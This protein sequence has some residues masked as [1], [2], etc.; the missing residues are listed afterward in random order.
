M[1]SYRIPEPNRS[2]LA[3]K[4]RLLR[5]SLI[6]GLIVLAVVAISISSAYAAKARPASAADHDLSGNNPQVQGPGNSVEATFWNLPVSIQLDILLTY[7]LV[8][9]GL[10]LGFLGM[11]KL[12]NL[13]ENANRRRVYEHLVV[14]PGCTIAEV[15]SELGM[16]IGTTNY[17]LNILEKE[18]KIC[19]DR[20]GRTGKFVCIYPNN[21][22]RDEQFKKINRYVR[23][24][25]SKD[26]LAVLFENPG[27]TNKR[28]TEIFRLNK[29]TVS[30]HLGRLLTDGIISVRKDGRNKLYF[31]SEEVNDDLYRL[32]SDGNLPGRQNF[33][34]SV[35]LTAS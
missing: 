12:K 20:N 32:T 30:W 13:L 3:S 18:H 5:A 4:S 29:S 34:D 14:N 24:R 9:F 21:L 25:V 2:D 1:R 6:L 27:I 35:T 8:S 17:H 7:L 19:L 28:L 33:S 15:A 23:N 16:N 22:A 26:V 31:I 10:G 11:G